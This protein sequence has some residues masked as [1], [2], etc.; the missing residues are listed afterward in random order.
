MAFLYRLAAVAVLALVAATT[1]PARAS[2]TPDMD[3]AVERIELQW[4]H[5]KYQ[6]KDASAQHRAIKQLVVEAHAVSARYPG[7]AE[8]LIWEGITN[9]EAAAMS[10]GFEALG[11]AKAARQ[12][13]EA[14]YKLD[15]RTLDAG[16]PTSLG[17]LYDRVPGFPIAFGDKAKARRYLTEAV[18][19]A[20]NGMDANWFYGA[21]LAGQGEYA[22]AKKVLEHAL[23]LPPHPERPLWDTG[24]RAEIRT[25]L[26][27]VNAKLGKPG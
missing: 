8:P 13:F 16:A 1:A 10:S 21:F 25:L 20:P 24:R 5:I 17:V 12:L 6:L 27:K 19:A 22:E 4:E 18:S 23:S 2:D 3:R 26:K 14:A 15:P 7:R 9:S 11:S